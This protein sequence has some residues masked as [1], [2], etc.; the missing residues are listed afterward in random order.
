MISTSF[1]SFL[2]LPRMFSGYVVPL[3]G[4]FFLVHKYTTSLHYTVEFARQPFVVY[5]FHFLFGLCLNSTSERFK[6]VYFHQVAY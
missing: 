5:L 1:F 3:V 4:C 2:L 6:L